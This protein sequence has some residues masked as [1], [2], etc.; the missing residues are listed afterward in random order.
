VLQGVRELVSQ[1][2]QPVPA[3]SLAVA[4]RAPAPRISRAPKQP[5]AGDDS[6]RAG[7]MRMLE[8]AATFYPGTMTKAQIARAAKMKITGGTFATYWSNLKLQ[9]AIEE[10]ESGLFRATE[11]GLARLGERLPEVPH[12]F[13]GRVAF[14]NARLREGERRILDAVMN[15]GKSGVARADLA[16]WVQMA[17]GGG[18]FATYLSTLTTN[19]LIA[20]REGQFVVHPWLQTGSE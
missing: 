6:L 9:G 11:S 18:T 1:V 3:R 7:A 4:S 2:G 17:E 14:W 16:S 12:D 8:V 19:R 13:K 10:V 5:T 20:K 15:A